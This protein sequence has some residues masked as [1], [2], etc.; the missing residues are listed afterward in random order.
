[1]RNRL[2]LVGAVSFGLLGCTVPSL[3]LPS[4]S[5][6]APA[7]AVSN[8]GTGAAI[9]PASAYGTLVLNIRWPATSGYRTALIPDTT[10]AL[11]ISVA[12]G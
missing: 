11:V 8:G 5:G 2:I 10:G 4:I 9:E 6:E 7:P 12:S 1:M 3:P